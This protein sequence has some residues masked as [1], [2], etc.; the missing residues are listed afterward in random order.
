MSSLGEHMPHVSNILVPIDTHENAV[1]VV[2][3][4]AL[5]AHTT[6]S[7]LI[8]LHVNESL[9]LMK[10]RPGLRGG[11]FPNLDLTLDKWRQQYQR[12]ARATLDTLV[13]QH[14]GGLSVSQ[15]FMEG[16]A[17]ATILGAIETTRSDFVVMGTHGR[18]WYQRAFLGSTAEAVLRAA[19]VPV[20]IIHN[21]DSSLPPPRMMRMLFATDFS[22]ASAAGE[23]WWQ[24]LTQHGVREVVL[25]HAVENP[26]LDVYSP[27]TADLDLKHVS[28]ESR[29]HPPRSAQPY[30]ENAMQVAQSRLNQLR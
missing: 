20:L 12:D 19:D 1:P 22:P 3:R 30:W 2:Q 21:S 16:R 11:G 14:C 27:D 15:L 29:Q 5:L 24:Y 18:P 17:H 10:D 25:V 9:E 7:L 6:N 26:L 23:E 28:E 13:Q 8:L 4:A